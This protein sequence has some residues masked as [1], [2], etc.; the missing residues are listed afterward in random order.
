[1]IIDEEFNANS[2]PRRPRPDY[3]KFCFPA[4]ETCQNPSALKAVEKRIFTELQKLQELDSIDQHNKNE[5]RNHFLQ[6]FKWNA[7]ILKADEKEQVEELLVEFSDIFAK[8]RFDDRFI[9]GISMKLP[10]PDYDQP[11]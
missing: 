6:R 1:M 2:Q 4:P 8:H 5:G 3:E 11:V 9:S 7:S 10:A